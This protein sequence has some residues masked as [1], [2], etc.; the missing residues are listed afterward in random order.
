MSP[1][2]AVGISVGYYVAITF[3]KFP[4]R[5][6]AGNQQNHKDTVSFGI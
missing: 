6:M 4:V 2:N 3:H 1:F 5:Y